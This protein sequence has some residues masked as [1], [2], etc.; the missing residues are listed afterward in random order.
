MK[1]LLCLGDSITDANRLFGNKPLGEGYVSYL[2][3]KLGATWQIRNRGVDGFTV[4][5][6]LEQMEREYCHFCPDVITLLIGINDVGMMESTNRT[7]QQKAEMSEEFSIT[8][9]KLLALLNCY[10]HTRILLLEPFLFPFPAEF[11]SWFPQTA[12]LSRRIRDIADK[13]QLEFLPL[14]EP[15]LTLAEENGIRQISPDGIHLTSLGH[16]FLANR[17]FEKINLKI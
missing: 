15:L 3:E 8:Y 10:G 12:E 16:K 11:K 1:Q 4:K 17:L 13:H 2:S 14:W 9:E 6:V 7:P 5:R